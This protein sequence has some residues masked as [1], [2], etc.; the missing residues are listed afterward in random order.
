M[1]VLY[2]KL[3][4][5]RIEKRKLPQQLWHDFRDAF[6]SLAMTM[7]FRLFDIKKLTTK[8]SIAYYRLRIGKYRALFRFDALAIYVEDIAPR[9]EVYRAWR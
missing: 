9:A 5:K 6:S 4:R 7:N 2:R 1:D 8:G 3:V